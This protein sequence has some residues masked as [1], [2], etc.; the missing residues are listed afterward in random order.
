[1]NYYPIHSY[2]AR[3]E[4]LIKKTEDI[5]DD[6]ELKSVLSCYLCI[7]VSGFLEVAIRNIFENYTIL[8]SSSEN[9]VKYISQRL[10]YFQNPN[11]SKILNLIGDF[12]SN[13]RVT[14]EKHEDGEWKEAV[15]TIVA[16]RHNLAH[17][18][19]VQITVIR[20]KNCYRSINSL[21]DFLINDC[22]R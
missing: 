1:M 12:S 13:W 16:N 8:Y 15:D 21:I 3:I 17:G 20:V 2:R 10:K 4:N 11:S 9:I 5:T 7:L 19:S 22:V 18:R 6:L 14:L